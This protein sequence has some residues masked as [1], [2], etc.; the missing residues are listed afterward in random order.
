[1]TKTRKKQI[2]KFF[3][4]HRKTEE[5]K[6]ERGKIKERS[7]E[8]RKYQMRKSCY[9]RKTS[10]FSLVRCAM[11]MNTNFSFFAILKPAKK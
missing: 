3:S 8:N 2:R 9:Y 1:M 4:K 7:K 10:K 11:K 5:R 6:R